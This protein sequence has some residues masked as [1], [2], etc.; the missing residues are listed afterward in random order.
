MATRAQEYREKAAHCFRVAQNMHDPT[1][2]TTRLDL[3][4]AWLTLADEAEELDRE[5]SGKS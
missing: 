1:I 4:A 3:S 2:R 5:R